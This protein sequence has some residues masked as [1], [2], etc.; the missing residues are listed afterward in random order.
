MKINK[1]QEIKRLCEEARVSLPPEV[2]RFFEK[3]EIDGFADSA[4]SK[5]LLQKATILIR[6]EKRNV[7]FPECDITLT[8]NFNWQPESGYTTILVSLIDWK[9]NSANPF[10]QNIFKENNG[11]E[12]IENY[13]DLQNRKVRCVFEPFLS[14]MEERVKNFNRELK[15][16]TTTQRE[17][18]EDEINDIY[19]E[20]SPTIDHITLS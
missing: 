11:E 1:F 13:F 6:V 14:E 4:L 9:L 20:E 5:N 15:Q 2:A 18:I 3:E 10:F 8:V 7:S 19:D 17:A 12:F 16:L